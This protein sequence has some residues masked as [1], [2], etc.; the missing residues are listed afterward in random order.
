[1]LITP[2]MI[3]GLIS[4]SISTLPT[5]ELTRTRCCEVSLRPAASSGCI[6]SVQRLRPFTSR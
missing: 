1:M 3:S 6:S 4:S 2:G 5:R